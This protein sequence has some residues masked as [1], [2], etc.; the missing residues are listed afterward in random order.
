MARVARSLL[1]SLLLLALPSL[2][3]DRAAQRTLTGTYVWGSGDDRGPLEAVFTPAGDGHWN[4]DFHFEHSGSAHTYSGT[5]DGQLGQ[6]T[7]SGRVT[8]EGR[9]R[10]FTFRG[11]FRNGRFSG[12]HSEVMGGEEEPTGTLTLGTS[13]L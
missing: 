7:L 12:T 8:S 11:E 6:G 10:V 13:P 1:A 4:V 5:A 3:A 2:A 9:R